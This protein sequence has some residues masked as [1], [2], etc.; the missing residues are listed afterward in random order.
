MT[1]DSANARLSRIDRAKSSSFRWFVLF[2]TVFAS[3]SIS[4]GWDQV[5]AL[6]N[7]FYNTYNLTSVQ[8]NLLY[9]IGTIP[10]IFLPIIAGITIDRLVI[11]F[12]MEHNS[13]KLNEII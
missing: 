8:F 11:R 2:T 6:H 1:Q 5:S 3:F 13:N 9:S 4:F 12:C 10:S 7:E